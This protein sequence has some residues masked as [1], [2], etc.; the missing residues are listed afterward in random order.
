MAEAKV[1]IIGVAPEGAASLSPAAR[2]LLARAELIFGGERLLRLFPALT[3]EKVVIKNNLAELAD[4]IKA[5]LGVRRMAVLASG[6]PDFFGIARYLTI[7][8][9]KEA[10]EIVPNISAMQ[11]AFARI[12]ESWDDAALVSVH[13][14]PIED[15]VETV[16]VNSKI[17]IFTDD[18]NTP[19][20][21]ARVLRRQGIDDCRVYV[22]QDLGSQKEQIISTNLARLSKARRLSPLSTMILIKEA[23]ESLNGPLFGMPD[24]RFRQREGNSLITKQEVRAVSLAQLALNE[25]SVVWDIGAGSGAVSIEASLLAKRGTVFSIEKNPKDIAIVREN[26]RRFRRYNIKVVKALAPDKLDEL[27][28]PTAVFVG[29]SGGKMKAILDSVCR[30][31][32]PGGRIVVNVATL[33]NLHRAIGG[34]EANG[35]S[36]ETTLVNIARSQ[37][38]SDLTRLEPLN[39]IFII[40]GRRETESNEE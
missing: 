2:R 30:R 3:A 15:I 24:D 8:L 5:N 39:P 32:K 19:T 7:R 23:K 35:F 18:K 34:L 4:M 14:R 21:I 29:G 38:I 11:V 31:L 6:D 16:R 36:A 26:I 9:G 12:K 28:D 1:Y 20:Q 27:P 13:S 10:I 17:G 22:C 25:N 33:E 40:T 37:D